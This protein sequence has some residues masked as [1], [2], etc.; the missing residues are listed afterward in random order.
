MTTSRSDADGAALTLPSGGEVRLQEV[1]FGD[2]GI[3]RFRFVAPWLD[4]DADYAAVAG[5]VAWLCDTVGLDWVAEQGAA[6]EQIVI[7]LADRALP[8]GEAAPEARQ[9]FEAFRVEG[10]AC[11]P[12]PF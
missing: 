10:G 1:R 12:E 6:P 4:A 9:M 2:D 5:D 8:F 11:V 7:S 3:A